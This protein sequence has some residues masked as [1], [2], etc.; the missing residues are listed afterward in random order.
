MQ[1]SPEIAVQSEAFE[2]GT[3]PYN[4]TRLAQEIQ[5]LWSVHS[6]TQTVLGHTKE[7]LR[8]LRLELGRRLHEMKVLLACPGRAG[9]WSKFLSE[10][11]IPRASADPYAKSYQITL[12]PPAEIASSEAIQDSEDE[13]APKILQNIWPKLRDVLTDPETAYHFVCALV[14]RCDTLQAEITDSGIAVKKPTTA[15]SQSSSGS[16]GVRNAGE[17]QALGVEC[18]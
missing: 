6:Q 3:A 18:E 1:V 9:K 4:E 17:E 15:N 5:Q 7:E 12:N 10:Q 16:L 2:I 8:T 11:R 13:T 14:Q